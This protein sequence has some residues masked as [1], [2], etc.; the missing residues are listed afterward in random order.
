VF[1]GLAVLSIL[2]SLLSGLLFLKFASMLFLA[3]TRKSLF[4]SGLNVD[5][6]NVT[7]SETGIINQSSDIPKMLDKDDMIR[8]NSFKRLRPGTVTQEDNESQVIK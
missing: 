1:F 5:E 6:V 7:S 8:I 4:D 2:L 3:H